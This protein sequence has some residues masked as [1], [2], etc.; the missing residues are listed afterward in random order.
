MSQRNPS[1]TVALY[2]PNSGLKIYN[3][4]ADWTQGAP[5]EI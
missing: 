3:T 1:T 2:A 4:N 5:F